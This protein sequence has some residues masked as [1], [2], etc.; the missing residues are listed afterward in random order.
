MAYFSGIRLA[1]SGAERNTAR[2]SIVKG[3]PPV[4]KDVI[5]ADRYQYFHRLQEDAR[6]VRRAHHVGLGVL[7]QERP[8]EEAAIDRPPVGD[9]MRAE[10]PARVVEY[11]EVDAGASVPR[12]ESGVHLGHRDEIKREWQHQ[13]QE[14]GRHQRIRPQASGAARKQ[15]RRRS[16]ADTPASSPRM[17]CR[18][19]A[20]GPARSRRRR[21]AMTTGSDRRPPAGSARPARTAAAG[22][23][24]RQAVRA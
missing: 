1:A 10:H 13:E 21:S 9:E 16:G 23:S 3:R 7:E 6:R 11:V 18:C 14:P 5:D 17:G 2:S 22:D 20:R 24:R 8:L 15:S 12:H 4:A 19:T